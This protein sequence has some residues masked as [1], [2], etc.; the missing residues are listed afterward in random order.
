MPFSVIPGSVRTAT[1]LP[2]NPHPQ[3]RAEDAHDA[4]AP[5]AHDPARQP[6]ESQNILLPVAVV[7]AQ[8]K[9]VHRAFLSKKNALSI[10]AQ[11]EPK[12]PCYHL[13]SR[14]VGGHSRLCNG[15][16]RPAYCIVQPGCSTATSA[17]RSRGTCTIRPLSA[18]REPRTLPLPCIFGCYYMQ[19]RPICQDILRISRLSRA[20][21][22]FSSLEM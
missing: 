4:A 15:S 11:G 9:V 3:D 20:M 8:H 6:A 16:S 18:L 21:I 13:N 10:S 22:R 5:L 12:S 14:P 17:A 19:Y 1:P 2:E 7:K